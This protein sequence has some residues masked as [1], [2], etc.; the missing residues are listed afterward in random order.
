MGRMKKKRIL[1]LGAGIS[2]L[3]AAWYLEKDP[4]VE[5]LILEKKDSPG[6]YME[7]EEQKGVFWEKGP[8]VFK[9][10]KNV[11]FLSLIE[12]V[13]CLSDIEYSSKK[14]SGRYLLRQG[15]L[16]KMGPKSLVSLLGPL[17]RELFK[18]VYFEDETV[19]DFGCRR[20]GKEITERF[21][22]PMVLGIYGGDIKKLS[23]QASFPLF[24]KLEKEDGSLVKGL[25]KLAFQKKKHPGSL[26]FLK[27]GSGFFVEKLVS[28]LSSP[29][30]YGKTVTSLTKEGDSFLVSTQD[31]VFRADRV[32]IALPAYEAAFILDSMDKTL[33]ASLRSIPYQDITTIQVLLDKEAKLPEGFGY[34]VARKEKEPLLGVIFDSNQK[35]GKPPYVTIMIEGL[36]H[37]AD[38]LRK[39]AERVAKEHLHIPYPIA[40]VFWTKIPKAIPQYLL[41]HVE[42]IR[43][44]RE[45]LPSGIH[46]MGNYLEGVS[47]SDSIASAKKEV[48]SLS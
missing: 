34:L 48:F 37:R 14:G 47:V 41:D 1:I 7:T 28:K 17:V 35:K 45:R 32:F 18:P 8:R 9:S 27:K 46:L 12:E 25:F 43:S 6:G 16:E 11:D 30:V 36:D 2:G 40:D 13:G 24:K 5:C 22:D 31:E 21:L 42:N 3:S 26:F 33:S 39:I 4:S 44:I 15:K 10:S 20:F 23:T 19:W 38:Q 29:I